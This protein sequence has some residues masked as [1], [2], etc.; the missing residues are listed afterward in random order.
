MR[1][2]PEPPWK[3]SWRSTTDSMPRTDDD[4]AREPSRY[5]K[6]LAHT[7]P[8]SARASGRT[9]WFAESF[10]WGRA[11]TP[12]HH[13]Q[14]GR[15]NGAPQLDPLPGLTLADVDGLQTSGTERSSTSGSPRKTTRWDEDG[16]ATDEDLERPYAERPNV[17]RLPP[18][19]RR[20]RISTTGP[21]RSRRAAAP[22][23]PT[24]TPPSAASSS[25]RASRHGRVT[26]R[27]GAPGGAANLQRRAADRRP[28]QGRVPVILNLGH[29]PELFKR[30]IDFASG[31]TTR[32]TAAC[33]GRRQGLPAHTAK[34]RGL[35]RGAREDA[36]ARLLEP[37]VVREGS[38]AQEWA[39]NS[40]T[41]SL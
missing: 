21:I 13:H 5:P 4:A 41:R 12:P 38:P 30:L 29:R 11:R 28:L 18:R 19:R 22:R 31:L 39:L 25:G 3:T 15:D 17:R 14:Q 32:S 35:R 27:V 36:R 8:A 34:R 1:H 20:G 24:T 7:T 40:R 9:R 37:S 23:L 10:R 33:S 16:Y 26:V 6:P 2:P